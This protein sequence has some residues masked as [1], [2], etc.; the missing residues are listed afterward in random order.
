[1]MVDA[2]EAEA[3]ISDAHWLRILVLWF[4][5]SVLPSA[6]HLTSLPLSIIV[7]NDLL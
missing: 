6:R 2:Y 5:P 1:M 3:K 7:N 4:P